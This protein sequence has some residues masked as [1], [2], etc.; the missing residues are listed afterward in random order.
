MAIRVPRS[1]QECLINPESPG[2]QNA[3]NEGGT[4]PTVAA[5]TVLDGATE[6]T[7]PTT[8][9]FS[10]A[11]GAVM[12]VTTIGTNN[13]GK[14]WTRVDTVS[15]TEVAITTSSTTSPVFTEPPE[16]I[17]VSSGSSNDGLST[18]AIA[19]VA[20]GT[21]LA[22]AIIA[23]VVA[24]LLYK[25]R[26]RKFVQKTCPSGYP[27]YADSSP[28]LVMVQKNAALGGPYV[29]ISQTQMRAPV[30]V[31]SRAIATGDPLA[32]VLPPAA[33]EVEVQN[34]VAVLFEQIHQHVDRFYRD[35]HASITPS[36][37]LDLASFGK[38]VNMLELLQ[39]CSQPTV[40]L[41]HALVVFILKVTSLKE[42]GN[43]QSLWPEYLTH[44]L[45][46]NDSD[47]AHLTTAQTLH[48]RLSVYLYT[49]QNTPAP[50][51]RSQSRLSNLSALSLTRKTSSAI[52]E[53]AEHFSLTF[54]PWANP[55]FGDQE[56]EGDLA[57]IIAEAL[58]SRIWLVGQSAEWSFEWEEPGRGT[59][60][61]KPA[62]VVREG[63]GP[64][65]VVMGQSV[66][67]I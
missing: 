5:T 17:P 65:R 59:V 40:A 3:S 21:F 24:W 20:I 14:V 18:G 66:G 47:S 34:R 67:V 64:R 12:V 16:A 63:G 23:L 11:T 62:V 60:V 38:D 6:A 44:M 43:E 25:R 58:E 61:L 45:H 2:C 4:E 56:R 1:P 52:R 37:D 27:I 51:T 31:P 39:S 26:D 46:A 15:A 57:G 30:P 32:G 29:Q 35:V 36:M 54:F 49:Q 19:G 41:K 22:G 8:A 55:S 48:R 50:T 7:Q 9:F 28:E 10:A 53:A 42:N 13:D 33:S